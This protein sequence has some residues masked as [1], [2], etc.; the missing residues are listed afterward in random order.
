M[1]SKYKIVATLVLVGAAVVHLWLVGFLEWDTRDCSSYALLL[2]LLFFSKETDDDER[3]RSLKLQAL[4]WAFLAGFFATVFS[5][6]VLR[7][8]GNPDLPRTISAYDLMFVMSVTALALFHFWRFQDGR[9]AE[10]V[11]RRR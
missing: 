8:I 10:S 7:Q 6:F 5:K 9:L 1:N 4:N 2:V 11:S 3:V